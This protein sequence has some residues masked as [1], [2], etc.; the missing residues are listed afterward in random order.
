ME[1]DP[2]ATPMESIIIRYFEKGLKPSIKAEIDWE[3]THLDNYK[4][5]VAKASKAETKTDLLPSSYI[6][7]IDQKVPRGSR[8]ALTTVHKVHIQQ[9]VKGRLLILNLII[10]YSKDP[11]RD[12]ISGQAQIKSCEQ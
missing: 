4:E 10:C 12:W 6:R 8:P 7:E 9:A 1:F 5:L 3:T 11:Q 2:A